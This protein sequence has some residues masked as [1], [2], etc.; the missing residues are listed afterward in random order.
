MPTKVVRILVEDKASK[1][2]D[3]Y[4]TFEADMQHLTLSVEPDRVRFDAKDVDDVL[5]AFHPAVSTVDL[6]IDLYKTFVDAQTNRLAHFV[7]WGDLPQEAKTCWIAVAERLLA[8]G[9]IFV[10][11]QA[12]KAA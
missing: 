1:R 10:S 3:W 6:A 11:P 7:A 2:M 8:L 9:P 12:S 5:T 4:A